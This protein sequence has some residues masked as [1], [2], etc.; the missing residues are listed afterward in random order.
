MNEKPNPWVTG[1]EAI[2]PG[3]DIDWQAAYYR[4]CSDIQDDMRPMLR[5]LGLF[6]GARAQSPQQVMREAGQ[7]AMELRAKLD[8]I[9]LMLSIK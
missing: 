5:A 7:R 3:Q 4:L 9:G 6:D 2:R 1:L 8:D